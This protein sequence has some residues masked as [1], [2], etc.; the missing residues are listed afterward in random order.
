[1]R[2]W[3]YICIREWNIPFNENHTIIKGE[4]HV[5]WNF[6]H[7]HRNRRSRWRVLCGRFD[8]RTLNTISSNQEWSIEA[9]PSALLLVRWCVWFIFCLGQGAWWGIRELIMVLN[10]KLY[11]NQRS[12]YGPHQDY[13]QDRRLGRNCHYRYIHYCDCPHRLRIVL[14]WSI[15]IMTS[16]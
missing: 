7:C 15:L 3:L 1:M 11:I 5:R 14:A 16:R 2:L 4:N 6:R 10:E 13:F 12:Y 8:A 9:E